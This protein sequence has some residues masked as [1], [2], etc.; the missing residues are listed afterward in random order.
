MTHAEKKTIGCIIAGGKSRRFKQDKGLFMYEGKPLIQ[1]ALEALSPVTSDIII[2]GDDLEKYSFLGIK[3]IPDIIP[4]LGPIGGI[5][6]GL[7][8]AKGNRIITVPCDMPFINSEFLSHMTMIQGGYDVIVP[9]INNRYEPLLAIY[10]P[11]CLEPI[12]KTIDRGEK[13][14]I[15]FFNEVSVRAIHE[16][17]I[18]YYGDPEKIFINVNYLEDIA[19]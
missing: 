6:S 11:A 4:R 7:I 2:A 16:E 17:E 15:A 19:P 14:I 1:Y 18:Q 9:F 10:G 5:Y 13:K 8:H 3:T 12:K